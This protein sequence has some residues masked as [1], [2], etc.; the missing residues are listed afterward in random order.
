MS[1]AFAPGAQRL[2]GLAVRALGWRPH[3]FWSATPSELASALVPP[4]ETDLPPDRATIAR[5]IERDRDNG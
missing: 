1:E 2:C 5:M 4:A 3:E